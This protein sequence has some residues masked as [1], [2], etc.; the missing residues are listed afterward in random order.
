MIGRSEVRVAT[1]SGVPTLATLIA[2]A[3]CTSGMGASSVRGGSREDD[4]AGAAADGAG[5]PGC[6]TI[7]ECGTSARG[8]GTSTDSGAVCCR[9][10]AGIGEGA[11]SA[12][13]IGTSCDSTDPVGPQGPAGITGGVAGGWDARTSLA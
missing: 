1:S 12:G 7:G 8:M 2:G 3:G 4:A 6:V 5:T 11:K 9:G 13:G 10:D